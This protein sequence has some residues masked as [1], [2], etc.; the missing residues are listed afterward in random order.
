[1]Q[2]PKTSL[3]QVVAAIASI[4]ITTI[5]PGHA[6]SVAPVTAEHGMVVSAQHLDRK[7]TRLNSSHR[8]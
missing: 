1:M 3:R 5:A 7:S 8:P 6:A 4:S 2:N